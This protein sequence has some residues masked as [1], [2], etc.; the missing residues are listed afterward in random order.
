MDS[1]RDLLLMAKHHTWR[2][3]FDKNGERDNVDL[4]IA[5]V[6]QARREAIRA[7]K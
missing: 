6:P 1:Q 2:I 5:F 4:A 7:R 3:V